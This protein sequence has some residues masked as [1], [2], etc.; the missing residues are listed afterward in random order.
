MGT[1][2]LDFLLYGASTHLNMQ[3]V[4][5][6]VLV[7]AA[8]CYSE[9]IDSGRRCSSQNKDILQKHCL[10]NLPYGKSTLNDITI[11]KCDP[12]STEGGRPGVFFKYLRHGMRDHC[13]CTVIATPDGLK[14]ISNPAC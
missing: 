9:Y 4:F 5:A 10:D 6:L 12:I 7:C 14:Q 1:Y 13:T 3:K 11:L 2:L 8:V